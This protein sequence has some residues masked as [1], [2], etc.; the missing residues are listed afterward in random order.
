MEEG[1]MPRPCPPPPSLFERI[2]ASPSQL[3]SLSVPRP[4]SFP[5]CVLSRLLFFIPPPSLSFPVSRCLSVHPP[6]PPT[7]SVSRLRPSSL[8]FS[9]CVSVSCVFSLSLLKVRRRKKTARKGRKWPSR[10]FRVGPLPSIYSFS[11]LFLP[12]SS[13][14]A[15]PTAVS[16]S[17]VLAPCPS[18][19]PLIRRPF[20]FWR[21]HP[22]VSES[23]AKEE[24][25]AKVPEM[26]KP[27]LS[28]GTFPFLFFVPVCPYPFRRERK[29]RDRLRSVQGLCLA[30]PIGLP[31]LGLCLADPQANLRKLGPD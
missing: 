11:C 8:P 6:L 7:A 16:L 20:C 28:G 2:P 31:V 13:S 9:C 19:V 18:V 15:F 14:L 26:V 25:L 4:V 27:A 21:P 3:L 17:F 29:R 12:L 10:H 30:L 1:E 24:H 22:T 5:F 23:P